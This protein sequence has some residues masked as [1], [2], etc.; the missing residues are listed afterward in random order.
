MDL[1]H[2]EK[3][4]NFGGGK[5]LKLAEYISH[6]LGIN[7][8]FKIADSLKEEIETTDLLFIDTYHT[9]IHCLLELEKHEKNVNKYIILHDTAP[10]RGGNGIFGQEIDLV[11]YDLSSELIF[12]S[13]RNIL[14]PRKWAEKE[15]FNIDLYLEQHNHTGLIPA[16]EYF[17]T[18]NP[19]WKI[20]EVIEIGCG[21]TVLERSS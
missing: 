13:E 1:V 4:N 16:I 5:N 3:Y 10:H 21:V 15:S 11:R 17:I 6:D 2:P 18:K 12:D 7:F 8:E 19:H 20:S 9:Y 14:I